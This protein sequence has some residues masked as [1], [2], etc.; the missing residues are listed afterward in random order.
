MVYPAYGDD[1]AANLA[2]REACGCISY[3]KRDGQ[4]ITFTCLEDKPETD[5]AVIVEV[6]V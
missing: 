3:A 6:Y 1:T 5:I 2:M 4:N